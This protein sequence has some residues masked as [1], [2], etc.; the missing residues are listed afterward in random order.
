[1]IEI[2]RK[3]ARSIKDIPK[4]ILKQL[5]SGKIETVNLAEWAAVDRRVLLENILVQHGKKKYLQPVLEK[6]NKIE[7]QTVN[8]ITEGIGE[9]ILEQVTIYKDEEFL[10]I[11]SNHQS[12]LVRTWA[13]YAVGK[14]KKKSIKQLLQRIQPFA[15]DK[16]FGVREDAWCAIRPKIVQ[17]VDESIMILSKWALNKDENIRRFATEATR[18]RG[19]WCEHIK[20]LKQNPALA[21]SILEPLK[22]DK[23]KYVRDSVGNWLN[24]A[25]KAQPEFV[26]KLCN[27]WKKESDTNE[28]KYIIKKALRTINKRI[29]KG[30]TSHNKR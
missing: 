8:T 27:R 16:H 14:I 24:D 25:S 2:K 18:P 17:N 28:T 5:N 1:M 9:G 30:G 15:A 4:N 21:M 11:I 26:I 20:E 6:I 13:A 10:E 23:A 29:E 12:D 3:G 22:S 7:K 19:V